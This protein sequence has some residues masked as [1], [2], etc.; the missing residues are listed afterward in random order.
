[1]F[2][3][4]WHWLLGV[5]TSASLISAVAYFLRDT[6]VRFLTR[7]IEYRFEKRLETFKAE[8][9][10]NER[11]LEQIREFLVSSRKYRDS[12]IQSKRLEAAEALLR[13]RHTVAQLSMLVEYMKIL[14]TKEIAKDSDNPKV[15]EFIDTLAKP[16][17]IKSRI[18]TFGEIDK[19]IPRL[20]LS[21]RSLKV[22]DV[23]EQIILQAAITM[24]L[25][26]M[27]LRDKSSFFNLGALSN[28]I[29]ELVPSSKEGFDQ[30]GEGYAYYWATYFHDEI[31]RTLCH[32]VSGVDDISK[33][34]ESVKQ[35]AL[36][37]RRA[38]IDIRSTLEQIGL[39]DNLIKQSEST[40]ASLLAAEKA[41]S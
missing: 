6:I 8:I 21:D 34:T 39:P 9:R 12:A 22:F 33:D 27:P 23:Y 40:E 36:D 11:E 10:E 28:K 1:M 37:S 18:K 32:E 19:T 26:S 20:Y 25:L 29:I 16:F 5:V 31:L 3:E 13:A 30:F 15:G 24:M 4:L 14:N 38:Q 17:D 41:S 7:K 2:S 35:L